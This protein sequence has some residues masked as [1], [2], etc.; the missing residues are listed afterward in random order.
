LIQAENP[1]LVLASASPSRRALFQA[2][3]L[4]FET[5]PAGI[6]EALIKLNA[7]ELG[8]SAGEA[9]LRLAHEKA[10]SL[11]RP[12][13]LVI[14]CDQILVCDH[15]WF[16]KPPSLGA[17]RTQLKTLRGRPHRLETAT[18]VLRDGIK[19]WHHLTAPCLAMRA[20]SD[21]FLDAY[22]AAEGEAVLGSVGAY[23][24]EGLGIHLFSSI[25]GEHSAILGLPLL[26]VLG[27]LRS[28]GIIVD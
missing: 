21:S 8:L 28:Y 19:I 15:T 9:A 22:L 13:A 1:P 27:F 6:D 3:G 11:V 18:V 16:D 25:E 4:R 23:R 12:G 24:L 5:C 14:G 17:A 2:A 20:F 26:P 10:A 7:H